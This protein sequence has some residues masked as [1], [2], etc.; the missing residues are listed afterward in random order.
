MMEHSRITLM[1]LGNYVSE[2]E[3]DQDD[4]SELEEDEE[5]Q[6]DC[7]D[8]CFETDISDAS[9]DEDTEDGGGGGDKLV[10]GMAPTPKRRKLARQDG[11]RKAKSTEK[12]PE[13]KGVV[14]AADKVDPC[15]TAFIDF[16]KL[17]WPDSCV[18]T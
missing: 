13:F 18:S 1:G 17:L 12:Y 11:L 7:S 8:D 16:V 4:C 15:N 6:D 9:D 2:L 3:E 14:G 5:D 10:D